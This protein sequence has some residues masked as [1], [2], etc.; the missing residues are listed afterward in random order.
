MVVDGSTG[1]LVPPG[2]VPALAR[3]LASVLGDPETA[4]AYGV[5]GRDR[6]R[7][8]TVSSVVER[9]EQMYGDAVAGPAVQASG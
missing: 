6:A 5:A 9:I 7:Q 2:D 3:A 8:F 1:L 4:S